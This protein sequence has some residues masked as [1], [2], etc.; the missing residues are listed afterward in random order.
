MEEQLI[1]RV[2][3]QYQTP[4]IKLQLNL[5]NDNKVWG[6]YTDT[7]IRDKQFIIDSINTDYKMNQ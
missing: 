2:T 3:N 7:T 4:S 6:L 1:Y 5:R